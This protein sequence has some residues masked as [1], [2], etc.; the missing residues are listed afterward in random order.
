VQSDCLVLLLL[1]LF[2]IALY[3]R[4]DFFA[5]LSLALAIMVKLTPLIFLPY[6]LLRKRIRAL[7]WSLA[8]IIF[9]LWLPTLYVGGPRNI[10]Y[11]QNWF[12][13]HKTN[14]G[15]YLSWYK[16]QSLLSLIQRLF[17]SNSDVALAQLNPQAVIL[18][19]LV[20]AGILFGLIFL[21]RK[22]CRD[23]EPGLSYLTD[24][25][26]VL[27]CMV[28]FSPL[29]W[30]HTF[31]HL[32][33]AHMAAL[34]Y[35]LYKNPADKITKALVLASFFLSTIL[36]PEMTRS[37]SQLLQKYSNVTWGTLALYAALLR[38]GYLDAHSDRHSHV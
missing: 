32:T 7:G 35:V 24:I 30:K 8:G 38:I 31:V 25:S 14:P 29:A 12:A 19:F 20:L 21:I 22:N 33:I 4:K 1:A 15:D 13:V 9:Y 11:I 37:F 27:I 26:L 17:A 23:Q 28:L 18:L 16:N 36:N 2:I 5:G 10:A 34:Y 3:Y 6:L